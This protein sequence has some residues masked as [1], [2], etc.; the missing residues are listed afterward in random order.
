MN[1][2]WAI[3][4]VDAYL[5]LSPEQRDEGNDDFSEHRHVVR[6]FVDAGLWLYDNDREEWD[7]QNRRILVNDAFNLNTT[8]AVSAISEY[9]ALTDEDHRVGEMY[10]TDEYNSVFSA[11]NSAM[12]WL[13]DENREEYERQRERR[14]LDMKRRAA[15]RAISAHTI[16]MENWSL[17]AFSSDILKRDQASDPEWNKRLD[18][19]R[20]KSH[21]AIDW[22]LVHFPEDAWVY[23]EPD[24]IPE[25]FGINVLGDS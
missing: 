21:E 13:Y 20:D 17:C 8:E 23:I 2:T 6:N 4:A 16:A 14:D 7:I 15:H 22:L 25:R 11:Y 9:L 24:D 5:A 3:A 1:R 19:S 12:C 18:E 10:D